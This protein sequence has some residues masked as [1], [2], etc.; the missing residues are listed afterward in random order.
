M[1]GTKDIDTGDANDLY[2]PTRTT[3]YML[4]E[5][6]WTEVDIKGW[7]LTGDTGNFLG[8]KAGAIKIYKRDYVPGR[9]KIDNKSA[10]YLFAPEGIELYN[11]V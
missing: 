8:A 4:R 3:V 6:S 9:Y 10:F 7:T 1:L 11:I 2:L 5:D